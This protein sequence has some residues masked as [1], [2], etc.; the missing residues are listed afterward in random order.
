MIG[1]K[2]SNF[3]IIQELGSGG[4]GTVYK[5]KDVRLNRYVAI[6]MLHPHVTS[7]SNAYKR[8]QNEAMISA[9]INNPHITTLFDFIDYKGSSYIIMEYVN[10]SAL[11]DLLKKQGPLPENKCIDLTIQMLKGLA[12]AHHLNILHRD[13]KPGNVMVNGKG[14]VK[15]MDFGI[16]RMSSATRITAQNKVIGTAEYIAPEIYLGKE[17]TKV[18]DLYSIGIILLELLSGKVLFKAES[19]ASL[20]YQVVNT[21]PK[22]KLV[23]ISPKLESVVKKLTDKNPKK[24]Y[25]TA[26]ELITILENIKRDKKPLASNPLSSFKLRLPNINIPK[27]V[28]LP[29]GLPNIQMSGPLKFL[30]ISLI[31]ST[32]IIGIRSAVSNDVPTTEII[33]PEISESINKN[34]G[35]LNKNTSQHGYQSNHKITPVT[36]EQPIIEPIKATKEPEKEESKKENV[37]KKKENKSTPKKKNQNSDSDK[38]DQYDNNETYT[39]PKE[40]PEPVTIEVVKPEPATKESESTEEEDSYDT[41]IEIVEDKKETSKTIEQPKQLQSKKVFVQ[42]QNLKIRFGKSISSNKVTEG[43]IIYLEAA[44]QVYID[45]HLLI[46]KGAPVKARIS[47]LKRKN[48]G[49]VH[50]GIQIMEVKSKYSD[51]LTLDYPEYSNIEKQEVVFP[52]S[53]QLSKVKLRSQNSEIFY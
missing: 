17:P 52:A 20:I 53:T 45:G 50:L 37:V 49:K 19:E 51:W 21:K 3:Q 29:K 41:I 32:I 33:E 18:S 22:I 14:F 43:Q 12:E 25:R 2:I 26:E 27:N 9:Q 42:E 4:M 16:A 40:K 15:I 6:K 13:L 31:V 36:I 10:G 34:E 44:Q 5:A 8:F 28:A 11:D 47:K 48:N 39:K 1:Q 7:Q 23:G 38:K 24:R 46:E 30:L 35:S